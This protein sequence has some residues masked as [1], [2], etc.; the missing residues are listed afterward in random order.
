MIE[1][2]HPNSAL[3]LYC[4]PEEREQ[5]VEGRRWF[6]LGSPALLTPDVYRRIEAKEG[7]R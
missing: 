5:A 7:A 2:A 4:G 6:E 1:D 3:Y